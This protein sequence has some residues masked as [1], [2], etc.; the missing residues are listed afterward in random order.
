MP[1]TE[2]GS[3]S[4]NNDYNVFQETIDPAGKVEDLLIEEEARL[5]NK[6]NVIDPL[7]KSKLRQDAQLRSMTLRKNAYNYMLAVIVVAVGAVAS[8]FF[9]N[10]N[11]PFPES[12]MNILLVATIGGT[13]VYVF[14]LYADILKR[15]SNDFEKV[16]FSGLIDVDK[17]KNP[18]TMID[19]GGSGVV[20]GVHCEGRK[21][22]PEG[23]FFW[24]NMCKTQQESFLTMIPKDDSSILSFS[25]IPLF[26]PV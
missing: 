20:L 26:T 4:N 24:N 8:L 14:V 21:C 5:N 7:Y 22:C 18:A 3:F 11:I 25:P 2:E 9:L 1:D 17:I 13:I 12:L 10:K 19:E 6:K 23:H 16:D 15:D